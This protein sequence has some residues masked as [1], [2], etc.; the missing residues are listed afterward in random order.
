[1]SIS[2]DFIK[3]FLNPI[4]KLGNEG[5]YHAVEELSKKAGIA[6][7]SLFISNGKSPLLEHGIPAMAM[8]NSNNSAIMLNR[9]LFNNVLGSRIDF[10]NHASINDELKAVIAHEMGHIKRGDI[11]GY[12]AGITLFPPLACMAGAVTGLY[13]IRRHQEQNK[14]KPLSPQKAEE[15]LKLPP[16]IKS[17]T[18]EAAKKVALYTVAVAAGLAT[19]VFMTKELRCHMEYSC[20]AFSKQIMGSGKPL[21]TF[22]EKFGIYA[23]KLNKQAFEKLPENR[24][25]PLKMLGGFIEWL[26]HPPIAKRVERLI[27]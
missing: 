3:N 20:D 15:T 26:M 10:A 2:S 7:P 18:L 21:A 9:K 4:P 19:G 6:V 22:L 16:E 25:K 24:R 13:L 11:K 17:P 23:E 1:M 27:R 14:D 12:I 8:Q 5:I